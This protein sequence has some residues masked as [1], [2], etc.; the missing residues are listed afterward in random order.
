[1]SS[2]SEHFFHSVLSC[3]ANAGKNDKG[4]NPSTG[5]NP[6]ATYDVKWQCNWAYGH[7]ISGARHCGVSI[8]Q[9]NKILKLGLMGGNNGMMNGIR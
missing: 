6:G 5:V 8:M 4:M 3:V 1:M 7:I 2:D 9:H